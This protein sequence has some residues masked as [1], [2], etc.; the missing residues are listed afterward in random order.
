MNKKF[1]MFALR[2]LIIMILTVFLISFVVFFIITL[3][4]GDFLTNYSGR[5]SEAGQSVSPELVAELKAHYGLDQPF[6]VQYWKWI[7]N[8]I[9]HGDFGY[10]F[11]LSMPG[12][13][14]YDLDQTPPRP[15]PWTEL[16]NVRVYREFFRDHDGEFS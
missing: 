11:L 1:W 8:I 15:R 2:K 5:M 12:V 10:S 9:L 16:E 13:K 4:P 7:S 6:V 14:I 3:P